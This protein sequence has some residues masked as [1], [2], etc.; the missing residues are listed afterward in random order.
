MTPRNIQEVLDEYQVGN[1]L[2]VFEEMNALK[3][4]NLEVVDLLR[5]KKVVGCK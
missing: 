4:W 1:L 5:D 3:E 2:V